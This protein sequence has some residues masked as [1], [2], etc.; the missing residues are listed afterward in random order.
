MAACCYLL[1]SFKLDDMD[2]DIYLKIGRNT[3]EN[4]IAQNFAQKYLVNDC[5]VDYSQINRMALEKVNFT[6]SQLYRIAEK[7]V[8]NK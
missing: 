5:E 7:F 6:L 2:D 4:R 1:Y 8:F 3:C